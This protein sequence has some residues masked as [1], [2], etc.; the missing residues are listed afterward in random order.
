MIIG[1]G[2]RSS[3]RETSIPSGRAGWGRGA[4]VAVTLGGILFQLLVIVGAAWGLRWMGPPSATQPPT[5][6]STPTVTGRPSPEPWPTPITTTPSD[7]A[8]GQANA[9]SEDAATEDDVHVAPPAFGSDPQSALG[10]LETLEVK[11]RAPKTGYGREAQFGRAWADVDANGCD[12]RNDILARDLTDVVVDER[13]RILAGLLSDPY[14]GEE[15]A[16]TRGVDTSPEVQIDHVVSLMDAW[17]KGAQQLTQ[18]D[19]IAFANDPL[20]LLAVS[21]K[22]NQ[23]KGAGDAATWLPKNTSYRCT[24]VAR[25]IAVKAAWELW[26]TEAERDAMRRVLINCSTE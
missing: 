16:F 24:Y 19:R 3:D 6:H 26:V 15:I 14:T 23:Q 20:N 11:G 12:T 5:A 9:G 18:E 7:Q 10:L 1:Q 13:C 21:G 4:L 17:Q 8:S 22:A 25:Q 2:R